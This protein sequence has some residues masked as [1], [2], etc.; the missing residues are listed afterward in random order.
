MQSPW[1]SRANSFVLSV[2]FMSLPNLFYVIF[3]TS[4]E[5]HQT[6]PAPHHAQEHLLSQ[7]ALEGA[8][9]PG[10]AWLSRC[11]VMPWDELCMGPRRR[12][13]SKLFLSRATVYFGFHCDVFLILIWIILSRERAVCVCGGSRSS[14][15]LQHSSDCAGNG[16]SCDSPGSS[17]DS[18][19]I[20]KWA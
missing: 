6:I 9:P 4:S 14:S 16:L 12:F 8:W 11:L 17:Y 20:G 2:I 5:V 1:V 7:P 15:A 13:G 3:S 10:R 18:L 19:I